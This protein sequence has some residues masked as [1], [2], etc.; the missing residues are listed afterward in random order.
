MCFLR[1]L[2]IA[3]AFSLLASCSQA[4]HGE[5]PTE[6][7][8]DLHFNELFSPDSGG[9]TGA[10]GLFSTLLPDG[11]SVFLTGD[12]FLGKVVDG[13]RDVGTKMLNNSMIVIN[14]DRSAAEAVYKGTYEQPESLFVPGQEGA[15]RHWYWPGHGFVSDSVLYVFAMNMYNNPALAV[16][17]EKD[18]GTLDEV[19]ELSENQWSF[20]VDGVDLLRFS[21]PDLQYLGSD[22]VSYTYDLDIHFGNSVFSEGKYHYFYGTRNDPD[23]SH[24]YVARV[25]RGDMPYHKNWEFYDGEAWNRDH[26][27]ARPMKLDIS[28]SEQFSIFRIKDRYVLLTHSK[29]TPDIYTYTSDEPYRGFGN[30]KFIYRSPE[31]DA[32]TTGNL[33]PYNAMA[34]PQYTDGDMLLVS[35]C[36]NSLRV[37]DVFE[38]ADNYRGRFIRIPLSRIDSSFQDY[39]PSFR[40]AMI[41]MRVEGGNREANLIKAK[42]MIAEAADKGADIILLPEA[43][44]LGWAHPSALTDAAPV[45]DGPTSTML[46]ESA[47]NHKVYICSGLVEKAEEDIYNAALLISPEGEILNHHRKINILDIAQQYYGQ[48]RGLKVVDTRFGSIGLM[49]CADGFAHQRVITQ[50]LCYMGAD[51]ILSPTA[52]ALPPELCHDEELATGI[53]FEHYAPVAGKF[54][55]HIAGCSNV[56]ELSDGPWKGYSAIGNSMLIGP[57]GQ[58]L[59]GNCFGVDAET[60]I[61]ND[62]LIRPR[63]VRGTDWVDMFQ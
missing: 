60:I 63:P 9:I 37:R 17:S 61:Y 13:Q 42:E 56:G 8:T 18:P 39:Q 26:H 19:D 55:V 7:E 32:D 31:Q 34:H 50:S 38:N 5:F 45:P 23:G 33:F 15:I 16:P 36:V 53:W 58:I 35:Y 25:E 21:L 46:I 12:C 1:I 22:Q 27:M 3:V 49:I 4:P 20:A 51:L 28:V 41:Q 30:K 57:E 43:M 10:D 40:L 52:W 47:R 14:R 59:A 62:V 6:V 2:L 48:G 11:R 24:I 44:D 54:N 29:M